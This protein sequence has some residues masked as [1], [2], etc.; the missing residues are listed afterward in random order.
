MSPGWSS[1]L[2][3]FGTIAGLGAIFLIVYAALMLGLARLRDSGWP[4]LASAGLLA[5]SVA[6]GAWLA[7]QLSAHMTQPEMGF[8]VNT[9][10]F[11]LAG[12]VAFAAM[13]WALPARRRRG[14]PRRA[15]LTL[16][17][18]FFAGSV[19]A[20][21]GVLVV[22]ALPTYSG[23]TIGGAELGALVAPL[24]ALT[25]GLAVAG[26]RVLRQRR[27]LS[28]S[29]LA[30]A[31]TRAPVLYLREFRHERQP[32]VSGPAEVMRPYLR[33][34]SRWVPDWLRPG[35]A[36]LQAV[37]A[38]EYMA[39][40]V[41]AQLGPFVALGSPADELP[42]LGAARE[43]AE[44]GDWQTRFLALAQ[45]AQAIMLV[46]GTSDALAWEL[47]A[48]HQA[49][50]APRLFVLVG[51]DSFQRSALWWVGRFHGWRNPDWPAFRGLLQAAGFSTP[52][53]SPPPFSVL[54]FDQTGQ[55]RWL[56]EGTAIDPVLY[57]ATMAARVHAPPG[58]PWPADTSV[59]APP[60]P[61]RPPALAQEMDDISSGRSAGPELRWLGAVMLLTLPVF[62]C[63][64][65]TVPG[66][67]AMSFGFE[68]S[69]F[70]YAA[71]SAGAGSGAF[72]MI[73]PRELRWSALFSGALA[74]LGSY[75][76]GV[77]LAG[78]FV[79]VRYEFI[80]LAV[81]LGAAPGMGWMFWRVTRQLDGEDARTPSPG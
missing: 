46:P 71:I 65:E 69:V 35:W 76:A 75:G 1:L 31:D 74:G 39:D 25:A 78:S 80:F 44:D 23:G 9:L 62:L 8:V 60:A 32:F 79:R 52:P 24:L 6:A 48:L 61:P 27:A 11:F 33:S 36:D 73:A 81:M 77:L 53:H 45:R 28:A 41:A 50:L 68:G 57:A 22:M 34:A 7:W 66:R 51:S 21:L 26:W 59:A 63:I 43:Y 16:A 64:N 5:A 67:V 47:R 70:D 42:P 29:A 40:A 72:L 54:G 3:T 38:E 49:G 55:G 20:A 15:G 14:G 17:A 2:I 58:P 13:A 30:A 18:A 12:P 56:A 10:V 4:G 19:L 37:S